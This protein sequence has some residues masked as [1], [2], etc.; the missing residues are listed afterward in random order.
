M[1][2]SPPRRPKPVLWITFW[3]LSFLPLGALAAF[4]GFVLRARIAL[5]TWPSP[6]HPDPK[7]LPFDLH[8]MTVWLGTFLLP[9]PSLLAYI[10][11]ALLLR[12]DSMIRPR[13]RFAIVFYFASLVSWFMLLRTDPGR[14]VEW[15]FD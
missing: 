6:Y 14:F 12:P 2:V 8:A 15:F 11:V 3:C 4:Y 9:I 5:G 7:D 13:A 1:T 10:V